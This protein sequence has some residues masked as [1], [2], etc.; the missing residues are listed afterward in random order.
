MIIPET[1][2]INKRL[3]MKKKPNKAKTWFFE[4]FDN[5][6]HYHCGKENPNQ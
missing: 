5:L 3:K 2:E 1:N 6:S 4:N